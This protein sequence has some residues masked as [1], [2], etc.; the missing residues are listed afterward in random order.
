MSGCSDGSVLVPAGTPQSL[1]ALAPPCRASPA[2]PGTARPAPPLHD[3]IPI[4]QPA[5]LHTSDLRPS[6][7]LC[8]CSPLL[9]LSPAPSTFSPSWLEASTGEGLCA[10]PPS[11]LPSAAR[12]QPSPCTLISPTSAQTCPHPSSCCPI[13]PLLHG[14]P[15]RPVSLAPFAPRHRR[16][17]L[18]CGPLFTPGIC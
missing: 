2:L 13:C 6:L 17:S 4:R 11:S 18:P 10:P 15:S 14:G 16:L 7:L 3:T 5:R 1:P 12:S 9:H 8:L